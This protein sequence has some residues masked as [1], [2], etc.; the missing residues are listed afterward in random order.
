[1]FSEIGSYTKLLLKRKIGKNAKLYQEEKMWFIQMEKIPIIFFY[2]MIVT[3]KSN[4]AKN[5]DKIKVKCKIAN[6]RYY[7]Y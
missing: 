5:I 3:T 7:C 2:V 6:I 4:H 1:M